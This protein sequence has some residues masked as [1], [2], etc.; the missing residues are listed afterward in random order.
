M[1][2]YKF[3]YPTKKQ[4]YKAIGDRDLLLYI[5]EPESDTNENKPVILFFNGGSFK[6][7][8]ITPVQFQ[9]QARFFSK[10][11]Y[12]A[13]CVDYRN[14]SDAGFTP[15]QAICDVKSAVRWVREHSSEMRIDSNKI[16]VCGASAGGYIAVSSIMFDSIDDD[17]NEK[18]TDH[19]PNTLVVFGAGM[20]GIDIMKR[21]YPELLQKANEYSPIHNVKKCLPQTLWLVGTKDDLFHQNIEFIK[22]MREKGNDITLETYEDMEHGFFNY[23]RH[24]NKTWL[25]TS[26]KIKDYLESRGY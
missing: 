12:V 8:P 24:N 25:N 14:G 4:I 11:N 2:N 18:Q 10:H 6:K 5:F 21:R 15:V 22:L 19:L 20:D 23:G 9:H 17:E 3:D 13:I 1:K 7:D 26:V 16:I